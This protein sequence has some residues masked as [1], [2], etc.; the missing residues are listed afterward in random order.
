MIEDDL[1][2]RAHVLAEPFHLLIGL[3]VHRGQQFDAV[4]QGLQSFVYIHSLTLSAALR[5][6]KNFID[7]VFIVLRSA[8]HAK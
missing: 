4:R 1:H 7:T 3:F 5:I 8:A 2:N 6:V